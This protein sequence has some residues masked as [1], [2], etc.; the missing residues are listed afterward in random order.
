MKGWKRTSHSRI[1]DPNLTLERT[2]TTAPHLPESVHLGKLPKLHVIRHQRVSPA[3]LH[4]WTEVIA[5]DLTRK[6]SHVVLVLSLIEP[7]TVVLHA[8]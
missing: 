4:L 2:V 7:Q 1:S 6:P 3:N 8:T 5:E